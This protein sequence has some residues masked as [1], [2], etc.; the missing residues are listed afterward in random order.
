MIIIF[1]ILSIIVF[2]CTSLAIAMFANNL[3]KINKSIELHLNNRAYK[4]EKEM[5]FIISLFEKYQECNSI[6]PIDVPALIKVCFYEQKI[7][8][9]N[10]LKVESVANKGKE[11]LWFSTITMTLLELINPSFGESIFSLALII[12]SAAL[13]LM[14]I[15]FELYAGIEKEKEKIFI[16]L[17]DYLHNEHPKHLIKQKEKQ[18]RVELLNRISELE[19]Q[20][21]LFQSDYPNELKHN[22]IKTEDYARAKNANIKDNEEIE[23]KEIDIANLLEYFSI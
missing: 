23:L 19:K 22:Y 7:G 10:T 6:N 2:L 15:F 8:M 5:R 9:F 12:I 17:Q 20:I 16:K 21:H 14:L 4:P 1:F 18:E 11:L 3:K 13:G